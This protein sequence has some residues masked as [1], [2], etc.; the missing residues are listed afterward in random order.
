MN[1][2]LLISLKLICVLLISSG[3]TYAASTSSLWG[4]IDEPVVPTK[5]IEKKQQEQQQQLQ[6]E[7]LVIDNQ[8]TICE[9][10]TAQPT[11][12]ADTV[13]AAKIQDALTRAF[14]ASLPDYQPLVSNKD[15]A[16][17][18]YVQYRNLYLKTYCTA[19]KP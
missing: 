2:K 18:L 9:L 11:L 1:T 4:D 12:A 7:Q 14:K 16:N 19:A 8:K 13:N 6:A 17:N 15:A 10:F 5:V 3:A